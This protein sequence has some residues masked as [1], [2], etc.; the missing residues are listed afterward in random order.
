M[1]KYCLTFIAFILMVSP[2]FGT[3]IREAKLGKVSGNVQVRVA[4]GPWQKAASGIVLREGDE[5]RTSPGAAAEILLDG[6]DV[7][8]LDLREDSEFKFTQL[9]EK[10][11]GEKIT[12]LDLAVGRV[13]VHAGK[14]KGDSKFEVRTPTST[15]GVRGT[16]FEVAVEKN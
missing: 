3:A 15:T 8:K 4:Q 7:G 2:C 11:N 9:L 5:V 1:K 10:S 14:L 6:G 12:L 16:V 13:L